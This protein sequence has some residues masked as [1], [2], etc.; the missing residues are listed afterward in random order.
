MIIVMKNKYK[1]RLKIIAMKRRKYSYV[2]NKTLPN[3]LRFSIKNPIR[4]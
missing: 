2:Y 4:S 3:E 1:E